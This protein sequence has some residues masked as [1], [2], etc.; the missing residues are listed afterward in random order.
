MLGRNIHV[1]T[2]PRTGSDPGSGA[3]VWNGLGQIT[4]V[5]R[6]RATTK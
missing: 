4:C 5:P 6:R 2:L 1:E 3:F